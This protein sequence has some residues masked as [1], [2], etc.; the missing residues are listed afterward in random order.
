[1]NVPRVVQTRFWK[2]PDEANIRT[3]K[4]Y[5]QGCSVFEQAIGSGTS[6]MITE[7]HRRIPAVGIV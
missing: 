3:C 4:N 7:G 2:H 6:Q 5:P 1:M